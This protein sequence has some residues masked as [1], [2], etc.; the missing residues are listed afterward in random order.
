[1]LILI[2]P[3]FHH[4]PIPAPIIRD[5]IHCQ[6]LLLQ[7]LMISAGTQWTKNPFFAKSLICA[8]FG[9]VLFWQQIIKPIK[10]ITLKVIMD[11]VELCDDVMFMINDCVKH[12]YRDNVYKLNHFANN[13][14]VSCLYLYLRILTLSL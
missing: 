3:S 2:N 9:K 5:I 4:Y 13:T 8:H 12:L 6:H 11:K 14:R 1:M 10:W 7:C